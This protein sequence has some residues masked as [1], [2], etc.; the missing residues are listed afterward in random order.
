MPP[1]RLSNSMAR[2]KIDRIDQLFQSS[3]ASPLGPENA[4][5]QR[6]A[7]GIIQ[8][9]L[10]CQGFKG[11][12]T[13]RSGNRYGQFDPVT[14]KKLKDFR[15]KNGLQKFNDPVHVDHWTIRKLVA[16]KSSSARASRGYI[17]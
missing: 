8:E 6:A 16:K 4:D 12:P 17:G 5:N 15:V 13:V 7:V 11:L 10:T 9:L 3:A 14:L 1:K 2:T